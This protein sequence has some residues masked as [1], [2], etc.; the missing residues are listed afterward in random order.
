MS[1]NKTWPF[2]ILYLKKT[3]NSYNLLRCFPR[4]SKCAQIIRRVGPRLVSA[5]DDFIYDAAEFLAVPMFSRLPPLLQ[6]WI[7]DEIAHRP[8][9]F[10]PQ[11]VAQNAV[12]VGKI[13][14]LEILEETVEER[15]EPK[16]RQ[17]IKIIERLHTAQENCAQLR[18]IVQRFSEI[19]PLDRQCIDRRLSPFLGLLSDLNGQVNQRGNADAYRGQLPN[20]C[21]HFPVHR[22]KLVSGASSRHAT[23]T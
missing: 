6:T 11:L 22:E 14:R 21:Q 18:I 20:R 5:C 7:G 23:I 1:M 4:R 13:H 12:P 8:I 9:D 2:R 3:R 17:S 10:P 19:A 16:F 15:A